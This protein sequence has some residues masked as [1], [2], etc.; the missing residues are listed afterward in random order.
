MRLRSNY[1]IQTGLNGPADPPVI[2][3]R[4]ARVDFAEDGEPIPR[5]AAYQIQPESEFDPDDFEMSETLVERLI[6]T[7]VVVVVEL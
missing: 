7:A 6:K 4:E 3:L 1:A 2:L 5:P